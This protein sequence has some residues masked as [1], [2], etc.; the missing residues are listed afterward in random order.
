MQRTSIAALLACSETLSACF[1][2]GVVEVEPEWIEAVCVDINDCS[3]V[4]V[5]AICDLLCPNIA[6]HVD[7][8]PDYFARYED[9]AAQCFPPPPQIVGDGSNPCAEARACLVST[10]SKKDPHSASK[11]DPP[12]CSGICC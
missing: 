10:D 7:F 1:G 3:P 9:A 12:I 2:S 6:I 4:R 11:R 5:G 8:F